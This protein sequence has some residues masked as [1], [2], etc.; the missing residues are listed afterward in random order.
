LP[1]A[2]LAGLLAFL[3]F[4][5]PAFAA[6]SD[7]QLYV[8]N[9][10]W[11]GPVRAA[12]A[13]FADVAQGWRVLV[14]E[15]DASGRLRPVAVDWEVLAATHRPVTAVIRI[16]GQL[17]LGAK[18]HNPERIA[19]LVHGLP[20]SVTEIEIDHDCGTARLT[21]YAR[22][23]SDLHGRLAPRRLSITAL[24]AWL[25]ARDLDAVLAAADAL[26]LQVHAVRA[27]HSGLFDPRT[28]RAWVDALAARDA[29]PFRVALPDYGSQIVRD[30]NGKLIAVESEMPRLAGGA[31]AEEL[32]A[33]RISPAWP[34]FACRW[35]AM[36]G[37][38]AR[39]RSGW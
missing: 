15:S 17:P 7:N 21:D 9:R 34:G 14:A 38:G 20:R 23:L 24:P 19:A 18:G 28:A 37:S 3:P 31:S 11:T 27:P 33:K 12:V 1:K 26:V 29:K 36:P 8:W 39:P 6:P 32:M 25:G 10:V 13:D 35:R 16:D 22:F 30:Q 4:C 5:S 2:W